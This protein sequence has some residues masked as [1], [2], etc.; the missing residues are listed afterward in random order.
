MLFRSAKWHSPWR[1]VLVMKL[2][3]LPFSGPSYFSGK[4][5]LA[6]QDVSVLL[7]FRIEVC[8]DSRGSICRMISETVG[9]RVGKCP[10]RIFVFILWSVLYV[11]RSEFHICVFSIAAS[12]P[13]VDNFHCRGKEEKWCFHPYCPYLLD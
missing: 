12:S 10:F 2:F 5:S 7:L 8:S 11:V 13:R 3:R 9:G 4:A 6:D 1:S